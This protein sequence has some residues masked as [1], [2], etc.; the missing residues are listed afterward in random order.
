MPMGVVAGD[1]ELIDVI[2]G[3]PWRFG[4]ASYPAA[5]ITG[6]GGT[7]SEHPVSLAAARAVLDVLDEG[8][9]TLQADLTTTTTELASGLNEHFELHGIPA[10]RNISA[11]L[12]TDLHGESPIRGPVPV[13]PARTRRTHESPIPILLVDCPRPGRGRA[14]G[15]CVPRGR[16][17][18]GQGWNAW[19][20]ASSQERP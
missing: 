16:H 14:G 13:L 6:S 5:D 20:T 3:G 11:L 12:P 9:P 1:S 10:T 7:T 19:T 8:G 17:P 15:A 18:H 4:D 2:D